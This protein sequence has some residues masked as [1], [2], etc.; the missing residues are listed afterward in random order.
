MLVG[1]IVDSP[2]S[3]QGTIA[4]GWTRSPPTRNRR[5]KTPW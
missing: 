1:E 5:S 3:I 2:E 4:A